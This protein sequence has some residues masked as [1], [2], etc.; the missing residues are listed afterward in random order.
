MRSIASAATGDSMRHVQIVKL[1]AHVRPAGR[2]LNA[3]AFVHR[4]ESRVAI[5]LQRACEIAKVRLR[6]LALAIRRI[7]EPHRRWCCVS[8]RPIVAH[9]RPQ[10]S[11]FCFS[12]SRRQHRNRRVVGVQLGRA[13]HVTPQRFHQRRKQLA[14]AAHP[15][16]QRRAFQLHSFPR[17]NFRLAIQ[18]QVIAIFR[19][20][21]MRQQP[22]PR[23]AALDGTARRFGLHDPFAARAGQLRS[24]LPDHFESRRHVLQNFRN[25]FAQRFQRAAAVR[26]SF[27]LWRIFPH[28]ARQVLGQRPF[29]LLSP[30][31][32]QWTR[33]L[34]VCASWLCFPLASPAT[35]PAATPV[36]R[37]DGPASPTC[38]RTASAAAWRS[39]A[40][41]AR[42]RCH[43]T[44][45]VRAGKG[46]VLS[47]PW[48]PTGSGRGERERAATIYANL[49]DFCYSKIKMC[50]GK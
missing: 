13:Q 6:M 43:A 40:L 28:L 15:V 42:S 23:N 3:P 49:A 25:V 2:F 16:R 34:P 4:I 37:S 27:L 41:N 9:I 48:D 44:T 50:A 21:H 24:H 1:S 12:I 20:Q 22:R 39:A 47:V 38:A 26:T 35:R 14:R 46:S 17:V 45:T 31:R 11:G 7:G 19:D 5:R 29:V 36:A 8:R 10:P 33:P 18:R 32:W 30:R